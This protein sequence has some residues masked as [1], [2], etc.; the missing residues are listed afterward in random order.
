M[1][2]VS[3]IVLPE[4]GSSGLKSV[5]KFCAIK[6]ILRFFAH[7]CLHCMHNVSVQSSETGCLNS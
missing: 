2:S 1:Y 5:M 6:E 4:E 7:E 3:S